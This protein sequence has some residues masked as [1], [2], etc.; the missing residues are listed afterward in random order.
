MWLNNELKGVRT[1][2]MEQSKN[3]AVEELSAMNQDLELSFA[4]WARACWP[5]R[6]VSK[7]AC[8]DMMWPLMTPIFDV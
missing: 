5:V 2:T 8:H 4:A 7:S 6:P 3:A 1:R